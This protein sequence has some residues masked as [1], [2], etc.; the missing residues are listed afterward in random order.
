MQPPAPPRH[1]ER[2]EAIHLSR[3]KQESSFF[4]KKEAKKLLVRFAPCGPA[5][6]PHGA[7]RTKSFLV[8]FFKKE[9]L[10]FLP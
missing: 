1:G 8:L 7:K 5:T 4:E 9:R 10:S 6:G 3:Q 2:S